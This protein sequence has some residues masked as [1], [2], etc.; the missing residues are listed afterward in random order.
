MNKKINGPVNIVRLEGMGKVI[1]IM[2][3]IHYCINHQ[4]KCDDMEAANIDKYLYNFF[5]KTNKENKEWDFMVEDSEFFNDYYTKENIEYSNIS[6]QGYIWEIR[7]LLINNFNYKIT[8]KEKLEV[9]NSKTFK[10]IRFHPIDIRSD[11]LAGYT[12]FNTSIY[13]INNNR[14]IDWNINLIKELEILKNDN[15][16]FINILNNKDKSKNKTLFD[17]FIYKIRNKYFNKN[18][19]KIINNIIDTKVKKL[20]L[21]TLKLIDNLILIIN[22]EYGEETK[23][24]FSKDRKY[25]KYINSMTDLKHF[26]WYEKSKQKIYNYL[27]NIQTNFV[28]LQLFIMDL[29]V[30]RRI[31]DKDYIKN[32]ILYNGNSHFINTISILVKEFG[33]KI[34]HIYDSKI[35][36]INKL[37]EK[38]K[39]ESYK[40]IVDNGLIEPE[41]ITQCTDLKDFPEMFL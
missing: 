1:Y 26:N 41:Y 24:W 14:N 40:N 7:R 11:R 13:S 27:Y 16:E 3:D 4:L 31:V 33:F 22:K 38:I 8:N 36:D 15:N 32:V 5:K 30:I 2:G 39:N 35:K 19:Q 6:Y 18:N 21:D 29:Y 25:K 28:F 17:K 37:N 10:N 9:Y 23:L 12:Y 20:Y 34:T